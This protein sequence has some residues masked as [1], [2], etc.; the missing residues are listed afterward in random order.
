MEGDLTSRWG[1]VLAPERGYYQS[2]RQSARW[3]DLRAPAPA[4][5]DLPAQ[6]WRRYDAVAV[7]CYARNATGA[8]VKFSVTSADGGRQAGW[9]GVGEGWHQEVVPFDRFRGEPPVDWSR[10]TSLTVSLE[11]TAELPDAARLC[12]DDLRLVSLPSA[13]QPAAE[14][15]LLCDFETEEELWDGMQYDDERWTSGRRSGH[16]VSPINNTAIS[17]E[18]PIT[19]WTP[20]QYVEFDVYSG[21]PNGDQ[22]I[23]TVYS[24]NIAEQGPSYWGYIITVDWEGWRHFKVPFR[25]M[26]SPRSPAGWDQVS[27]IRLSSR[28]WGMKEFDDTDLSFD[29]MILTKGPGHRLPPG[30]LDDFEEGPYSWWFMLAGPI[31]AYREQGCGWLYLRDDGRAYAYM[32]PAISDWR[33]FR[34]LHVCVYAAHAQGGYLRLIAQFAGQKRSSWVKGARIDWEG[35]REL[36]FDL[37]ATAAHRR[38]N[39][40]QVTR[41]GAYYRP[42][43]TGATPDA[44]ICLDDLCLKP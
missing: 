32:R 33:G 18:P 11:Q 29:R 38:L 8:V 19:D 15:G 31:P 41:L 43:R 34:Q 2:G 42:P 37:R 1:G 4:R 25:R 10:V 9:F 13:H 6:S 12:L 39:W 40:Q 28:G 23:F 36:V 27:T 22:F 44:M 35:W 20:Y 3:P 14:P 5:W 16:W 26:Y 17:Y 24:D 30:M 7:S 21:V